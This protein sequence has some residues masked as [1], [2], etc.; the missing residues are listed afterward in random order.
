VSRDHHTPAALRA[1]IGAATRVGWRAVPTRKGFM[2]RSPDGTTQ[3]LVHQSPSD[4]R[5]LRN[6]R[7][8]LRRAGVAA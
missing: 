6:A 5:A 4:W 1:L 2:L 8:Q 7:A 3:V